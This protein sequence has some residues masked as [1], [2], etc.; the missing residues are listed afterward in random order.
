MRALK[1]ILMVAAAVALAW[2]VWNYAALQNELAELKETQLTPEQQTEDVVIYLVQSEPTDFHLVPV[3]RQLGGPASPAAALQ[4]LL[5][6]PLA[7]EELFGAVPHTAKLLSLEVE[8]GLAVADFSR[9]LVTDFN[10][11]A[12]LESY[13]VKAIVNTLTEFPQIQEVQ[14]LVEGKVVESIGGHILVSRPLKRTS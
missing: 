9:E 7:H 5:N 14:I 12:Q 10:G 1:L 4:A 13:L 8:D 6:G 3:R 2:G 11:G